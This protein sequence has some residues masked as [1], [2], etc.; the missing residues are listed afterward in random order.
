MLTPPESPKN[1]LGLVSAACTWPRSSV[2]VAPGAGAIS[3][4][5]AEDLL[6]TWIGPVNVPDRQSTVV[7]ARLFSLAAIQELTVADVAPPAE[8]NVTVQDDGGAIAEPVGVAGF[9][10]SPSPAAGGV[11]A[12][13]T[14]NAL[15]VTGGAGRVTVLTW[16]SDPPG[17]PRWPSSP[18]D[19]VARAAAAPAPETRTSDRQAARARVRGV[20]SGVRSMGAP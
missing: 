9:G 15:A 6:H 12:S 5:A 8:A 1:W 10:I 3:S 20:W 19:S 7:V 11:P 16:G 18:R 13:S 4:S 2:A 17:T 14:P